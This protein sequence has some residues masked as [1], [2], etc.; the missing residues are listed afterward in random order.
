MDS[1]TYRVTTTPHAVMVLDERSGQALYYPPED[2]RRWANLMGFDMDMAIREGR[3]YVSSRRL[4]LPGPERL[5]SLSDGF[6][7]AERIFAA[8]CT[9]SQQACADPDD[10]EEEE[11]DLILNSEGAHSL[12]HLGADVVVCGNTVRIAGE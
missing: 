2:A 11:G 7:L 9:L 6:D 5:L 10:D 8:G 1:T 12:E 3:H 4:A